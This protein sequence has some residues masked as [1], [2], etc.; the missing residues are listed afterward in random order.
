[1][2]PPT[3]LCAGEVLWDVLPGGEFLGGAPF[4]VAGH[5]ARLGAHALLATRLGKDQRGRRALE[6]ARALG[7]DL[8]LVQ[9]D[10]K[11][12]TGEARATLDAGGSARYEFLTQ[13][14]WD[15]L[16]LTPA[17]LEAA[18][19]ADAFVFGTL[20]QRDVRAR[21]TIAQLAA[22]AKWRVFDPNLR[23][24]HI[25]RDICEAGLKDAGLVKINEEECGVL[26]AWFGGAATPEALWSTLAA[27][28][29]IGALCVT[30]GAA[31][32][33]LCWQGRWHQQPAVPTQVADTVGAGDSFLAMLVLELLGG[34]GPALALTR[35]ARLAAFVASQPG[36]VPDYAAA[37][38]RL[39]RSTAQA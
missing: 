22:A 28:F 6:L 23:A 30:L 5:S 27:R 26:A 10:A 21:A 13:A 2:K 24:P 34:T 20:G 12:P 14:A 35:A 3:V 38:F 11:L 9:I 16:A 15:A 36:A 17:L 39:P 25:E 1:V 31:G 7:I 4:N 33:C 29:R 37:Q 32:S 18:G 19:T 8:S